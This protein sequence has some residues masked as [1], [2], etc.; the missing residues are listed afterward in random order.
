MEQNAADYEW[1][2]EKVFMKLAETLKK[3]NQTLEGLFKGKTTAKDP[4]KIHRNKFSES[5]K[6]LKPP[7]DAADLEKLVNQLAGAVNRVD[8]PFFYSLYKTFTGEVAELDSLYEKVFSLIIDYLQD[9][10][11][12]SLEE[13]FT[14]KE[15]NL[16]GGRVKVVS[17]DEFVAFMK[18]DLAT[19][20]SD[21]K[22]LIEEEIKD[23]V[24][25]FKLK[26]APE[27]VN[28]TQ[29]GQ[30][31]AHRQ[32]KTQRAE[33]GKTFAELMEMLH[34]A[35]VRMFTDP[36]ELY[37][38]ADIAETDY[39]GKTEFEDGLF[40]IGLTL[41][42]RDVDNFFMELDKDRD[43]K[44][45]YLKL[46]EEL[47]DVTK[48]SD[49]LIKPN[50]PLYDVFA[51]IRKYLRDRNGMP[52]YKIFRRDIVK[53]EGKNLF[54]AASEFRNTLTAMKVKLDSATFES[55]EKYLDTAGNGKIDYVYFNEKLGYIHRP[56]A[57][58]RPKTGVKKGP[59]GTQKQFF[60]SSDILEAFMAR[61]SSYTT[62]H[63]TDLRQKFYEFD[64]RYSGKIAQIEFRRLI[65]RF[66][67]DEFT[68]AQINKVSE[69]FLDP[70][71]PTKVDYNKFIKDLKLFHRK[72]LI[73][74]EI[75]I[76]LYRY[77]VE[78]KADDLMVLLEGWSGRGDKTL[79]MGEFK[80][81]LKE[82]CMIQISQENFQLVVKEFDVNG[83]DMVDLYDL[84]SKFI[85]FV[86][87]KKEEGV[88]KKPEQ[89]A[90]S[91]L[92]ESIKNYC[93]R[94]GIGP[95]DLFKNEDIQ[96][97]TM[98]QYDFQKVLSDKNG[99][100][101]NDENAIY[102]LNAEITVQGRVDLKLLLRLYNKTFNAF[103]ESIDVLLARKDVDALIEKIVKYAV[104]HNR[105]I[106]DAVKA[107]DPERTGYISHSALEDVWRSQFG[108]SSEKKDSFTKFNRTYDQANVGRMEYW[109]FLEPMNKRLN[110]VKACREYLS[111]FK[112]FLT[113]NGIRI[114]DR[115]A[116][117]DTWHDKFLPKETVKTIVE[118][119]KFQEAEPML[120]KI[121]AVIPKNIKGEIDYVA[122][123]NEIRDAPDTV[124]DE[125][126]LAA[127]SELADPAI[128]LDKL[129]QKVATKFINLEEIMTDHDYNN[130]GELGRD[131]F[132]EIL[133]AMQISEFNKYDMG[134][135]ADNY[136]TASFTKINYKN[137]LQDL[138]EK[139]KQ[140][141]ILN[142]KTGLH[143]AEGILE[144]MALR[145]YI[146]GKDCIQFYQDLGLMESGART[147]SRE[148]FEE[149]IRRV[150]VD[151][152]PHEV[153]RMAK[154]LAV[155]R[156]GEVSV[157]ELSNLVL[158]KTLPARNKYE[159][160]LFHDI[161][162]YKEKE[163]L[164]LLN[165][166]K[167]HDDEGR[168]VV[169]SEVFMTTV[170]NV[171]EPVL[172]D[173]RVSY[174]RR[175]Y[176]GSAEY[177]VN[178]PTFVSDVD[179]LGSQLE[180]RK[181][182][183]KKMGIDIITILD[184][185]RE[186]VRGLQPSLHIHLEAL[187]RAG[188]GRLSIAAIGELVSRARLTSEE[189][190]ALAEVL[191]CDYEGVFEYRRLLQL[192]WMEDEDSKEKEAGALELCRKIY[193]YCSKR[194]IYLDAYFVRL[195]K[196]KTGYM[197]TE[198]VK[199]AFDASGIRLSHTQLNSLLYYLGLQ[200]D[201]SGRKN[202]LELLARIFGSSTD[203]A[204]KLSQLPDVVPKT[205]LIVI[206]K[207]DEKVE[208]SEK[209]VESH[210]SPKVNL[211]EEAKSYKPEPYTGYR[212]IFQQGLLRFISKYVHSSNINLRKHFGS[213]DL[214]NT[215]FVDRETFFSVLAELNIDLTEEDKGEI[216]ALPG[217]LQR[218]DRV[219]YVAF[220]NYLMEKDYELRAESS[221]LREAKRPANIKHSMGR[222]GEFSMNE[223]H[224]MVLTE[225]ELQYAAELIKSLK[226]HMDSNSYTYEDTFEARDVEKTGFLPLETFCRILNTIGYPY[227][228][229][230]HVNILYAYLR[231]SMD[232]EVSLPRLKECLVNGAVLRQY[233]SK[234]DQEYLRNLKANLQTA[235]MAIDRLQQY[236]RVNRIPPSKFKEFAKSPNGKVITRIEFYQALKDFAYPCSLAESDQVFD[237]ILID[238][239]N[240]EEGSLPKLIDILTRSR[241]NRVRA[242]DL[243][244]KYQK[245]L[246]RITE[247]L[248]N[249]GTSLFDFVAGLDINKDG[250]ITYEEF[251]D[252][253]GKMDIGA[254][255]EDL[256]ELARAID[257]DGNQFL[258]VNEIRMHIVMERKLLNE[259]KME[260]GIDDMIIAEVDNLF[261]LL[262]ENK[263]GKIS[264]EEL[265]RGLAAS[266]KGKVT[267]EE[268]KEI[269][270]ALDSNNNG[271]LDY[272]EFKTFM[273]DQI[274]LSILQVE[275]SM[276]D[277]RAKFREADIDGNGWLSTD[278]LYELIKKE[279]PNIQLD[280]LVA[281]IEECDVDKNMKIDIDEFV[282]YL[283]RPYQKIFSIEK[284]TAQNGLLAIKA[285]RKILP[286]DF[287]AMF[288]RVAT[289]GLFFGSFLEE[290]LSKMKNLP[291]EEF[292]L[293]LNMM[294]LKYDDVKVT[295]RTEGIVAV[296]PA[297][298][299]SV[300]ITNATGIPIPSSS[301]VNVNQQI[302]G[303]LV[304][305]CL[306]NEEK[307][308][309]IH[310]S[311]MVEAEWD[312][313]HETTWSF[314][315]DR[316]VGTNPVVFRWTRGDTVNVKLI[317]EFVLEVKKHGKVFQASNGWAG[318]Y[319]DKLNATT[320]YTLDLK[321]GTP[322]KPV[323]LEASM[324]FVDKG[325]SMSNITKALISEHKSQITI[326]VKKFGDLS[327]TKQVR[328]CL[329]V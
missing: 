238:S 9:N 137:F 268:V 2:K 181:E 50:E 33:G 214:S 190:V 329:T 259:R 146:D 20:S 317:F 309:F 80:S 254:S 234:S 274:K 225:N 235:Q 168:G 19:V 195:A 206:N 263:D 39:I 49:K 112:S 264:E 276:E 108:L 151:V 250:Y 41:D 249:T 90:V 145:L 32:K 106:E 147:T 251:A 123:E 261:D 294:S 53:R 171:L 213:H 197:S 29:L 124:Y 75:Y 160:E 266:R 255:K 279:Y 170:K 295:A 155:S 306:Y 84:N 17:E 72:M 178:Y 54:V 319:L 139:E 208:G 83:K 126:P 303:R 191:G 62:E 311:A 98:T 203:A 15:E 82:E 244:E 100:N 95:M 207:V 257:S 131:K 93:D 16:G 265:Y 128:V 287:M 150:G 223:I 132:I 179:R 56:F 283:S 307:E 136:V 64:V 193:V 204:D 42:S 13:N 215:G 149:G 85:N 183:E 44:I 237:S 290:K 140:Y 40:K 28:I 280:E 35:C 43:S 21:G 318:I 267:M 200:T 96:N 175:R 323:E 47:E 284:G 110:D 202:Y 37:K 159:R 230:S 60:K 173:E 182:G 241:E 103:E 326:M 308:E 304:R 218:G 61:F 4:N 67:K 104:V 115:F 167:V 220:I 177:P 271:Y 66:L 143:W 153:A 252:E 94:N 258:S 55:L 209:P 120:D 169:S 59:G 312:Q 314:N 69:S 285:S 45:S 188:K 282:E 163:D 327:K 144:N 57:A 205:P 211:L 289:G 256:V 217:I 130:T 240:T 158:I 186:A 121:F 133:M 68:P 198:Q 310:N 296:K 51:Q 174:I 46:S 302:L 118:E 87:Q 231:T 248:L 272:I 48:K 328:I 242:A 111:K 233:R 180:L 27:K 58:I 192:L 253:V 31:I 224:E 239:H 297:F 78:K 196:D 12:E 89:H 322:Q 228:E 232:R 273:I 117:E 165:V 301:M 141:E 157:L 221:L 105:S 25:Y 10:R 246:D 299:G 116:F 86:E 52:L 23:F 260:I 184:K 91:V 156:S 262:D 247:S 321:G 65:E 320:E 185:L 243:D 114:H 8:L 11:F 26:S 222:A 36:Y 22:T 92:L 148:N 88:I 79:S 24:Q 176:A 199:Q 71:D 73:L 270:R 187:D 226:E 325:A 212:S 189:R 134:R 14:C 107:K 6:Q 3:S 288:D 227:T 154:E 74:G 70:K 300:F 172:I 5:I 99:L 194:S 277:L 236:M 166:F 293:K 291:S 315:R 113:V 316:E 18:K 275:D 298:A 7:F 1:A 164:N 127:P 138:K 281:F 152:A 324:K 210:L 81:L 216:L 292:L 269:M 142:E 122:L 286:T 119:T 135:L 313:Q 76:E 201:L 102:Q 278:E 34:V 101:F 125:G 38:D 129:G 305:V 77:M 161:Y 229:R 109:K 30:E 245:I 219:N 63:K 97:D 162:E